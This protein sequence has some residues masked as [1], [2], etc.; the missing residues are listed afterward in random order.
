M[1]DTIF[2]GMD[3]HKATISEDRQFHLADAEGQL[4]SR[5]WRNP[6]SGGSGTPVRLAR[7]DG[8]A[9]SYEASGAWMAEPSLLTISSGAAA[10]IAGEPITARRTANPST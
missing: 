7:L 10:S 6:P 5:S 3:V 2:V 4:Y 1:H 8:S 9:F